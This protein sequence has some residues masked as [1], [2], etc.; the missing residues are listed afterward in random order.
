MVKKCIHTKST[1]GHLSSGSLCSSGEGWCSRCG[2]GE[3][4]GETSRAEK[5]SE[6]EEARGIRASHHLQLE[7]GELPAGHQKCQRVRV[8][9]AA[10]GEEHDGQELGFSHPHRGERAWRT[11][12]QGLWQL[13]SHSDC[14][15]INL[16][17]IL[18]G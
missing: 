9:G 16:G 8:G 15:V 5:H 1:R 12:V 7:T 4:D 17:G 11:D 14:L 3:G 2:Q 13:A 6:M 10:G 18:R